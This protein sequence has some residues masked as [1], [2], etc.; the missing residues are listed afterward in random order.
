MFTEQ[1]IRHDFGIFQQSERHV[2]RAQ[3]NFV[4][5][6]GHPKHQSLSSKLATAKSIDCRHAVIDLNES[7]G[8]GSSTR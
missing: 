6:L 8:R 1:S 7:I 4:L 5:I 2:E 3:Q